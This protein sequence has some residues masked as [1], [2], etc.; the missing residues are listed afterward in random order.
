MKNNYAY[1]VARIRVLEKSLLSDAD[2]AQMVGMKDVDSVLDYLLSKG[3]GSA[4]SGRDPEKIL[5]VEAEKNMALMREL[6]IDTS[7]FDVFALPRR[8]HNLKTGIKEICSS[9][10]AEGS[11]YE[12]DGFGRSEVTRIL[13]EKEYK[14]LPE[15]MREAAAHAYEIM[16]QTRDGQRCDSIVDRA[17]LIAMQKQ[18]EKGTVPIIRDYVN[19]QVAVADIRIAVRAA[20]TGKTVNFLNEA[21]APC[22]DFEIR[23][24]SQAAAKGTDALYAYLQEHRYGDA[25]E[26]LKVSPS[27]FE[28]W[29]DNC[30]IET[31]RPQK[32]N[33][34][35]SGPIVA[36]YLARENE[37]KT[38]RIIVTAKENGFSEDAI[39]ERVR[40]M[41]V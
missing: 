32:T 1:A 12:I 19:S 39:R 41:Y 29:C 18:V 31:I 26:A 4:E 25:V 21:L 2:V 14:N 35:T 28:R 6:K 37:I 33:P 11:Y 24:L 5:D 17:C 8:F 15:N 3:W 30:L 20:R 23:G 7:V 22:K 27:A 40:E 13:Q 38:V 16:V 34:F 36:F 9:D 10:R